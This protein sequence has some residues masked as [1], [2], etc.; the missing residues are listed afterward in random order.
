MRVARVDFDENEDPTRVHAILST[1]EAALVA[2]LVGKLSHT[3]AEEL[4]RGGGEV[5]SSL[6][7]GMTGAFFN[8]YYDGGV[9]EYVEGR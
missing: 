6:Y 9:A 5:S 3:E 8:R 2:K 4:M 7:E 1:A